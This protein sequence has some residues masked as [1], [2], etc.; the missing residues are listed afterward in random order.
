MPPRFKSNPL[1][2]R[3]ALAVGEQREDLGLSIRELSRVTGV[4]RWTLA[5]LE[6]GQPVDPETLIWV[7]ATLNVLELCRPPARLPELMTDG[8]WVA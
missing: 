2:D 6:A 7:A 1:V 8:R 4:S 5:R 3:V